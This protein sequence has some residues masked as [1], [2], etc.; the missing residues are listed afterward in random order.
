MT[1]IKELSSLLASLYAAPLEPEMWQV[2]L[3]RLCTMTNTASAYMVGIHPELG[4]VTLAGGGLDFNPETL[5]LYNEHYGANDPYASPAMAKPRVGLIEAEELVS[6]ADLFRSEL[7]NEVLRPHALEHMVLLSCG[8]AEEAGLFPMWRS[9]G[10]GPMDAASLDLLETLLPHM[11]MALRLRTKVMA[12]NATDLFSEA[13]LDAMSVA[14]LLVTGKGRVRQMNKLAAEYLR[15]GDGLQLRR[16]V[17]VADDS[18]EQEK[19]ALLIAGAAANGRN[20]SEAVAG[21]GAIMVS[22]VRTQCALQVTVLP[23]PEQKEF[24]GSESFALIMVSDPSSLPRPR[25][26]LM[27]QLFGLTPAESRLTDLLLNGLEVREAAE[28]LLITLE[29]ARF[30][31]KRV[32]TKTGTHR[33]TELMRLMLSLPVRAA[34]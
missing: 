23:V 15:R 29:T 30:H 25:T 34:R 8:S 19:L 13:A 12:C 27:Q 14:A 16:N 20:C 5:R 31:L 6:R 11:Q 9:P 10:Q 2:F 26:A 4:N 28:R 32:L 3:D 22:R 33:Q 7:Y 21:G 18:E 24:A 1:S 17:L